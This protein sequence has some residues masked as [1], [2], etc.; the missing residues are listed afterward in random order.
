MTTLFQAML[1][2]ANLLKNSVQ[3][4]ATGGGATS[5]ACTSLTEPDDWYNGG[6]I[7][8]LT[9]NNAGKSAIIT[10]WVN[11]TAT[12]SFVTPG[13][14]CAAGNRFAAINAM[15][16]RENMV[17][18]VNEALTDIGG[19]SQFDTTLTTVANQEQYSLPAGVFG[20]FKVEIAGASSATYGWLDNNYWVEIGGKLY[21]TA[22]VPAVTGHIIRVWYSNPGAV[23][24]L[25]A[26]S[27]SDDISR[28]RLAWTAAYYC[29]YNQMQKAEN[30]ND[31]KLKL[32][33]DEARMNRQIYE[34]RYPVHPHSKQVKFPRGW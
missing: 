28:I 3:G 29:H 19:G 8:F 21:F 5:L 11:S 9:G 25:D 13:A 2:L 27:I 31:A 16:A 23:V 7:F 12:F 6:T 24:S 18:A 26:D 14:A 10:D 22:H 4:T 15:Y 32:A 34:R 30:A 17:Q 1:D 20:V 33:M